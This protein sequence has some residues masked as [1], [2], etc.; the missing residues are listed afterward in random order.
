[1]EYDRA[2]VLVGVYRDGLDNVWM[3]EQINEGMHK[4][5]LGRLGSVET[6]VTSSNDVCAALSLSSSE[7]SPLA[8]NCLGIYIH[9]YINVMLICDSNTWL[10]SVDCMHTHIQA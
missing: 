9:A 1:M 2:R 4:M 5:P 3:Y 8:I 6:R 10:S 7:P